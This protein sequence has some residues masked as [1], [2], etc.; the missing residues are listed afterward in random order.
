VRTCLF[1]A[2]SVVLLAVLCAPSNE[3]VISPQEQERIEKDMAQRKAEFERSQE[4]RE[5]ERPE[6]LRA[7]AENR[8]VN[9]LDAAQEVVKLVPSLR[10]DTAND[11][12]V[13]VVINV[14]VKVPEY[15]P[16]QPSRGKT[17]SK[18]HYE[19][20]LKYK[21]TIEALS[22]ASRESAWERSQA[23]WILPT[24]ASLDIPLEVRIT[25]GSDLMEIGIFHPDEVRDHMKRSS[26]RPGDPLTL[27][28]A[29]GL[30]RTL[31]TNWPEPPKFIPQSQRID[32][33]F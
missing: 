9:R 21:Q 28:A 24:L 27:I 31:G 25:S 11:G 17:R 14:D 10:V 13:R 3:L 32:G 12:A 22:V 30:Y 19:Q 26:V 4:A 8:G 23:Q 20:R 7:L 1:L 2:I 29:R 16:P 15:R 6:A 33:E 18:S 5:R